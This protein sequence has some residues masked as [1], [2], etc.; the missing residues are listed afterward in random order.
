MYKDGHRCRKP[1]NIMSYLYVP[2]ILSYQLLSTLCR[3]NKTK[4]ISKTKSM[5]RNGSFY[6]TSVDVI[7]THTY[8]LLP[9]RRKTLS[10]RDMYHLVIETL[11]LTATLIYRVSFSSKK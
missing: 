6:R 3:S 8:S 11:T 4:F 10:G 5:T 9:K 1:R 2:L 7:G